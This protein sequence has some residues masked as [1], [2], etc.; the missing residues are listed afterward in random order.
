MKLGF[1]FDGV[2]AEV[3]TLKASLALSKFGV[4]IPVDQFERKWVVP[5]LL[6]EDQYREINREVFLNRQ[7]LPVIL[8]SVPYTKLLLQENHSI[9]IFTSR[10]GES[11]RLAQELIGEYGLNLPV[12]GAGYGLSKVRVC[13]GLDVYTDD[14]LEKL[15]PLVGIV[16]HLLLFSS[17]QN[18]HEKIP[19]G[20]TRVADWP[21][22]YQRI[23]YEV[24]V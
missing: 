15:I 10:Y 6:T 18:L 13:K 8:G 14:D 1:D 23:R 7:S 16:P 17:P 11:L 24:S 22:V 5:N 9:G 2:Y 12:V 21:A 20:I 19:K 3:H 4:D